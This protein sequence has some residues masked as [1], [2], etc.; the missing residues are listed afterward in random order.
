MP[1]LMIIGTAHVI[2][3][4]YPLEGFIR[5]FN[6]DSIALELD[7][8][9]WFALQSKTQTS[10]GPFFLRM[11][12]RIQKYLGESFGSS[13]GAEMLV[14]ANIARSLNA[15]IN[16][17]DKPILPTIIGAWKNMPWIE[18]WRII[19]DSVFSFI[20][21]G[22]ANFSGSMRTGDFSKELEE[23]SV[24]YP[25]IK[26]HLIDRRDTY[27]SKNLIKLFRKKTDSRIVA[28]VGEGHVEGMARK[29]SSINPRIVR[30]SDLL[31]RSDN[32]VSF[33]IKI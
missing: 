24:N 26:S 30:L 10:G 22:N 23:F 15:E 32:T 17:I 18:L 33:S 5:E 27:M 3:L 14:A 13:P 1:S 21:K 9:R 2:D 11:L 28:I 12:A 20:G 16:L 29:L 8:D 31:S 7:R 19:K 25:V 6:P 4:S